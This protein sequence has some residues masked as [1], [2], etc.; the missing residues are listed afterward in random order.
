M[1]RKTSNSFKEFLSAFGN[2]NNIAEYAKLVDEE[3]P[4]I[5]NMEELAKELSAASKQK[6]VNTTTMVR[7]ARICSH[8]QKTRYDLAPD[9]DLQQALQN[10]HVL[11]D[12]LAGVFSH[13]IED[14]TTHEPA[15]IT[16]CHTQ[17]LHV[18][19]VAASLVV[20]SGTIGGLIDLLLDSRYLY[21]V[22]TS[23]QASHVS[24]GFL[25]AHSHRLLARSLVLADL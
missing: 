8:A 23:A 6:L 22:S 1:S 9:D 14:T 11:P 24:G 4:L 21:V 20:K 15:V 19:V 17:D 7:L 5:P 12:S 10:L 13:S 18:Q 3:R 2:R 25:L 16:A